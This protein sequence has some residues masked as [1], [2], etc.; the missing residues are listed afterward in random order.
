M[1]DQVQS[2]FRHFLSSIFFY[3]IM[4]QRN[5]WLSKAKPTF[6]NYPKEKLPSW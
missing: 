5:I 2:Y 4:D 6:V 3:Y 1:T